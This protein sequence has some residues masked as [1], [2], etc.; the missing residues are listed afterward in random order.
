MPADVAGNWAALYEGAGGVSR[1]AY[2]V[3][4]GWPLSARSLLMPLRI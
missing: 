4:S 2:S 3:N 1:Q